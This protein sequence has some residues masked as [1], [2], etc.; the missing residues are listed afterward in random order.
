MARSSADNPD[1]WKWAVRGFGGAVAILRE[2]E[3][4]EAPLT[5]E[6]LEQLEDALDEARLITRRLRENNHAGHD[7]SPPAQD[8]QTGRGD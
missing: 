8:R 5:A 6:Q 2:L 3:R 7:G 1:V 4:A